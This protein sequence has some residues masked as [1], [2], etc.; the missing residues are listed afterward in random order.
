MFSSDINFEEE[1]KLLHERTSFLINKYKFI[2]ENNE[3]NRELLEEKN[4]EL[5][6][7]K[8]SSIVVSKAVEDTMSFLETNITQIAN[9]ALSC[10]FD[11]A[12][13]MNFVM[14]TRGKK[15]Q[16]NTVK[17]ELKKDGVCLSRNLSESCEGGVLAILSIILRVAFLMLKSETRKI[18][19][20]D[21]VLAAVSRVPDE[22]DSSN[23]N[24][25]RATQLIEKISELFNVQ[26]I[27]VSHVVEK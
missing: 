22:D 6:T 24:L 7:M 15:T 4:N 21:E 1:Y 16:T 9:R 14:G 18:L 25:K 13:T 11:D 20:L 5:D 17:I 2:K 27:L 3:K 23:S 12:Y 26:I 19:L 8:K 10:V